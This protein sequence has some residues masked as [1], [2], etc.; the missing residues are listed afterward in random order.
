[1]R[2][3][4]LALVVLFTAAALSTV[5]CTNPTGPKPSGDNVTGSNI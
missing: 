3:V 2:A 4:R 1:M 5:A